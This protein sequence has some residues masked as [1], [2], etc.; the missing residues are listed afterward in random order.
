MATNDG[1]ATAGGWRRFARWFAIVSAIALLMFSYHY[2]APLAE[3]EKTRPLEPLIE[4]STGAF[5]AGILYFGI[6]AL[7]R[8]Y[9]LRR[10]DWP[11]R[12]PLYLG[13]MV[14]YA[15]THTSMMWASRSLLFPLA[16]LGRYDY[17]VMPLRYL[18][19]APFQ[20][21]SFALIVGA[22]HAVRSWRA[23]REQEVRAARLERT[24]VD[25]QLASLRVQLQPHFL[26]NSLNTISATMYDDPAAADELLAGLSDLL[27][28]SLRTERT[29][30]VPL[31]TELAT[32]EGYLALVRARFG[33]RLSL[34]VESDPAATE[35][36]VPSMLLQPLVENAI[37]HG[38]VEQRGHG[39]V[40]VRAWRE[41]AELRVEVADDGPGLDPAL[42][43][44]ARTS[45][46]L[47][48]AATRERLRL[49][50]GDGQEL[51]AANRQEGGFRVS[52]RIPFHTAPRAEA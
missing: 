34:A 30:E 52:I 27:R 32:L 3:G 2:L 15:V 5:A 14:L 24:L 42:A 8:R 36:L 48:L 31:A 9:P 28:A 16:G 10:A 50:Y 29:D 6:A 19:E 18:M 22:V 35:A 37:R 39:A 51:R 49:L 44:T 23:A 4:E 26:F 47:G 11:G 25:A 20:V 21:I 43:E 7:V 12:L 40:A 33:E 13:A 41:S 45:G 46:G 17:G 38:G 1:S